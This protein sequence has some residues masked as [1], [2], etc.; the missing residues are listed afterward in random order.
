MARFILRFQGEGTVPSL[1]IERVRALPGTTIL[2]ESLPHLIMIEGPEDFLRAAL[3]TMNGW[4]ISQERIYRSP[5]RHPMTTD[6]RSEDT[7]LGG[8]AGRRN[9]NVFA[10]YL[11]RY[12]SLDET[13]RNSIE[14]MAA[15]IG[16]PGLSVA[17]TDGLLS[18][19]EGVLFGEDEA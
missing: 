1:D 8:R 17:R 4:S 12:L 13:R 19:I 14:T 11:T 7:P 9:M 3:G 6:A 15:V 16:S 10:R 2:D 18:E 5:G